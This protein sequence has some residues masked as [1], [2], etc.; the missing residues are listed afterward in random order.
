MGL[1]GLFQGQLYLTFT[2]I[3]N[4]ASKNSSLVRVFVAAG[5]VFTKPLPSNEREDKHTDTPT[6][7]R[8]LSSTPPTLAQMTCMYAKYR[9]DLFRYSKAAKQD[10]QTHR[11]AGDLISILFSLLYL[12]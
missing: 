8:E 9:E 12:F 2:C 11:Q 5:N 4:D 3:E 7:G 6:D 10:A 1:H